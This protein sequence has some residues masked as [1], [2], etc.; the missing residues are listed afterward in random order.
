MRSWQ[1]RLIATYSGILADNIANDDGD[2]VADVSE[3]LTADVTASSVFSRQ[4]FTS[5]AF[6]LGDHVD[7][8]NVISVHSVV[9]KRMMD[10]DDIDFIP[11]SQGQMTIPTFL[12]K[13]VV[14]DDGMTFTPGDGT[15]APTY[16]SILWGAGAVGYGMGNPKVPVEVERAERGGNG[17]GVET[18]WTRKTWLVHPFGFQTGT[19]PAGPSYSVAELGQAATWDRVVDRKNVPVSFLITN[20]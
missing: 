15:N 2:M 1:R 9:Y 7:D 13:R 10:N 18:L 12:G 8:I 11:D 20:G 6:T 14:V 19:A 17:A 3:A 5:A 16:T 4:A